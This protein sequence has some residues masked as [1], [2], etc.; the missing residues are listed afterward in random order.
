MNVYDFD[1]TIYYPNSVTQFIGFCLKRHPKLIFTF[2]PK[3]LKVA[4]RYLR[5][6]TGYA[7]LNAAACRISAYLKEPQ[8]D[9]EAFWTKHENDISEWYLKQKRSDDLIISAS[10]E[11][12][13]RPLTEKLGVHLIGTVVDLETGLL[14]GNVRMA[15]EKAKYIIEQDMPMMEG[16]YS[17]SL[18]DT[19][20]ALLAE[21]AYLVKDKARR[22]E[23]W[24]HL[25][26]EITREVHRKIHVDF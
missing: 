15:R 13:L 23:P 3:I 4:I 7:R 14:I 25:T 21:N 12:L 6:K 22:P 9:I 20:I 1:G 11:Y 26:P 2:L 5:G 24:P 16:F 19:P 18:S 17:D 8:K 10:P